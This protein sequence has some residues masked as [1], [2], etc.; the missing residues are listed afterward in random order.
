[1]LFSLSDRLWQ[2]S[3]NLILFGLL[4]CRFDSL[5]VFDESVFSLLQ[6]VTRRDLR[7]APAH[8][9]YRT[10]APTMLLRPHGYGYRTPLLYLMGLYALALISVYLGFVEVT[11]GQGRWDHVSCLSSVL[12]QNLI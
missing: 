5:E 2:L 1:M 6:M 11:F 4:T 3:I 8:L 9:V 10:D 12:L 7:P